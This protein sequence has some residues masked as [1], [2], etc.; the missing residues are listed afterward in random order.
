VKKEFRSYRK[1]RGSLV[2]ESMNEAVNSAVDREAWFLTNPAAKPEAI[3]HSATP[4]LLQ[5]LS[6]AFLQSED[7]LLVQGEEVFAPEQ[8]ND[9]GH[10][11]IRPERNFGRALALSQGDRR[12]PK[13]GP[14]K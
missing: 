11:E 10:G 2:L 4:E 1:R 8:P 12:N 6:S 13:D 14:E 5:L 9:G 3:C 7:R